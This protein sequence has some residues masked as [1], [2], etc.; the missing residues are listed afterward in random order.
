MESRSVDRLNTGLILVALLLAYCIP[1]K[2]FLLSY[3]VL[4]PL[5][6]LT[7]I[8]WLKTKK[9]F[10][11]KH[12]YFVPVLVAFTLG[13]SLFSFAI[14]GE[15]WLPKVI[16]QNLLSTVSW[17]NTLL[18]CAL[19][20]VV[21]VKIFKEKFPIYINVLLAIACGLCV[22]FIVPSSL[23]YFGLFV[24]TLLHVYV[25][26]FL[27][28]LYGFRRSK[29]L[30]GKVNLVLVLCVPLLLYALPL[31]WSIELPNAKDIV[32]LNKSQFTQLHFKLAELGGN[33][34]SQD[35]VYNTILGRK[36]Q[37]FIA[38]AYLYHYLNWFSKTSIIGWRKTLNL[39]SFLI[40]AG[41]W[42]LSLSVYWYDFSKGFMAL[43]FLSFLHVLLEFPLNIDTMKALFNSGK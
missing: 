34:V 6:Y 23:S 2:L 4:G 3:A 39:K 13:I 11:Y 40:I 28:M 18:V 12:T 42:L 14:I 10:I 27:F 26:T 5:H 41:V 35:F 24:P 31:A 9:F 17:A 36:L 22:K 15:N 25:F 19:V 33:E 1:F 21:L 38:F 20:L 7:E 8:H 43:F 29:S 37:V 16:Y 30:Y 32:L